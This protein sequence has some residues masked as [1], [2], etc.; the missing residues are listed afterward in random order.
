MC[1]GNW[2]LCRLRDCLSG[3]AGE[4]GFPAEGERDPAH[5]AGFPPRAGTGVCGHGPRD[6][7]FRLP[8]GRTV[9]P[10][11]SL[12]R[13]SRHGPS[14]PRRECGVDAGS[15][16]VG[17]P[18]SIQ[19]K[20]APAAPRAVGNKEMVPPGGTREKSPGPGSS[21][22]CL[23]PKCAPAPHSA[24][25]KRL[26]PARW[27]SRGAFHLL[28]GQSASSPLVRSLLDRSSGPFSF[29]RR[30]RHGSSGPRRKC[31]V[32]RREPLCGATG[33]YQ[34]KGAPAAL[35][36][37][38]NKREWG[39]GSTPLGGGKKRAPLGRIEKCGRAL[40]GTARPRRAPPSCGG[41]IPGSKKKK[42]AAGPL[43]LDLFAYFMKR[44]AVLAIMSFSPASSNWMR[45]SI[46]PP[47]GVTSTIFPGP[48]ALCRMCIPGRKSGNGALWGA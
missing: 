14:G 9:G 48:K 16:C 31:G 20:G 33:V 44:M 30:S 11:I 42:A 4:R 5:G 21:F 27:G 37:V 24:R 17:R 2:R 26:H 18:E 47:M 6:E 41:T 13:H 25:R 40:R 23:K 10:T 3:T 8:G 15:P 43:F 38:G 35:C 1:K 34:I 29:R 39:L 46:S 32:R 12:G 45:R 19:S 22:A 36:A 7:R 28:V